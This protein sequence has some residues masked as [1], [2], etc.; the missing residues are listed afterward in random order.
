MDLGS[1]MGRSRVG[2]EID[3]KEISGD[4]DGISGGQQRRIVIMESACGSNEGALAIATKSIKVGSVVV[5]GSRKGLFLT[6][7]GKLPIKDRGVPVHITGHNNMGVG[8]PLVISVRAEVKIRETVAN[9]QGEFKPI[10]GSD[11]L[12]MHIDA[13]GTI[14]DGVQVGFKLSRG[15]DGG[16]THHTSKLVEDDDDRA[17]V[18]GHGVGTTSDNGYVLDLV[19]I[20]TLNVDKAV[21]RAGDDP[22]VRSSKATIGTTV[23]E[24]TTLC[25]SRLGV[26][27]RVGATKVNAP[28]ACAVRSNIVVSRGWQG[29]DRMMGHSAG[30][31]IRRGGRRGRRRR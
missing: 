28:V 19:A 7:K 12:T 1:G 24:A 27:H 5:T 2:Q 17:M 16:A 31:G 10:I 6:S 29:R 20:D 18:A 3:A 30:A 22:A 8:R 25:D 13:A 11:E 21:R 14:I 26:G 23:D 4:R 9:V 15:D